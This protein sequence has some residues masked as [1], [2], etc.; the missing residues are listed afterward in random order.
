MSKK[1]RTLLLTIPVALCLIL[2]FTVDSIP[3]N[4]DRT[5][6]V[7]E[8]GS[9]YHSKKDCRGLNNASRIFEESESAAIKN[10]KTKCSLCWGDSSN[11][12]N[13]NDNNPPENN[14][15][16]NSSNTNDTT[17]PSTDNS[18]DSTTNNTTSDSQ[19]YATLEKNKITLKVGKTSDITDYLSNENGKL[20]YKSKNADIASVSSS[21]VIKAKKEGKAKIVVKQ[22][23][24][25]IKK[26]IG[27]I[28]VTV[29]N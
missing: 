24:N 22:T 23:I 28:T 19:T 10:G 8:S 26:K 20:K 1:M 17:V 16:N 13:S 11:D 3:V 2:S 21:G 12:N 9:K 29:K 6:Y 18:Q 14:T 5:V 25:G 4:A 15:N 27:V 7:T